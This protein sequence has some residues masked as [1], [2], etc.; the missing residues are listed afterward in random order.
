MR[1]QCIHTV[2]RFAK[3][4]FLLRTAIESVLSDGQAESI[5]RMVGSDEEGALAA[6]A[7]IAGEEM[8]PQLYGALE[9]ALA[10][11]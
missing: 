7:D 5:A 1:I 11:L 6:L 4:S 8:A 10:G 3:D 2:K 9:R